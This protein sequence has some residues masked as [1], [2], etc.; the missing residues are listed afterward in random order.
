M[1]VEAFNEKLNPKIW[2]HDNNLHKD[3]RDKVLEIVTYFNDYVTIP[4]NI[5]DIQIVG[6]NASYN[7]NENSDLDIHII[8]DFSIYN[9]ADIEILKA[10]YNAEKTQFNNS[11]DI[12]IKGIEAEV[13]V[14]DVNQTTI[15]NGIYSLKDGWIKFPN[16]LDDIVVQNI[17]S[18]LNKWIQLI[19]DVKDGNSQDGAQELLD[20]IYMIRKNSLAVDGEYGIGNLLFKALRAKGYIQDLRNLRDK[21][22]SKKLTLE[23]LRFNKSTKLFEANRTQLI[24]KSK[25][26][27]KGRQRYNR[28]VK[29][30]MA[31]VVRDFNSIDMNKLFKDDILAVDVTVHGETD[32]YKVRMSFG[33]FLEILRDQIEK[34][35][36]LDL[37]AITR[38]LVIG[39]NKDDVY[40]HCT[41]PDFCLHEDTK[42]KLLNNEV[43]SIKDIYE[44]F[45][46]NE[47]LWV[48]SVDENG[49]FKPGKVTDVWISGKVKNLI[50]V[51]LDNDKEIV[52]T[53]NHRYMLRDGSFLE[54]SSLKEG[55]SLMPLYFSYH[56][57]YECVKLNSQTTATTFQS[58]YKIVADEILSD[59][60][61]EAKDRSKEDVICIHHA[62]F[63]K[64]NNF[65]SNLKPMGKNEHW[66][67]HYTH[68]H[69]SGEF[70]KWVAGCK[71]YWAKKESRDKQAI[72]MS[73]TMKQY[74]SNLSTEQISQIRKN[75]GAYTDEWKNN[76]SKSNKE[77]WK[78]Y[79][80]EEYE[81][82]CNLIKECNNRPDVKLKQSQKRKQYYIDHPEH[83][84][85]CLQ[86]IKLASQKIKGS[87]L[88]EEHKEKIRQAHL[89]FSKEAEE[90]RILKLRKTLNS[91]S[92]EE[93]DL[94][95]LHNRD[96][97]LL[98]II[99]YML[100]NGISLSFENYKQCMKLPQYY[101][102]SYPYIGKYFTTIEDAI[103]YFGLNNN[104]NHKIKRIEIVQ[105][106]TEVPVYDL[107][108]DKY[109]NFYVDAG[110]ILHNCYR[111]DYYATRNIYNSGE[112]Q[113]IPSKITNPRDS[114]GSGCK[115]ILLLLSNT[116]WL[117]K[118]ASVINNYIKY[119]Q[120]NMQRAYTDIIYPAIYGKEYEEPVQLSIFDKDDLDTDE[121]TIDKS[122]QY[123]R[124][125]TQ[126]KKGNTQGVRFAPNNSNDDQ[127]T[128]DD[129]FFN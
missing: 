116:A 27:E 62:D 7:W 47:E 72:Q 105:L 57:G 84:E 29:S 34:A 112:P 24:N 66:K 103:E 59:K 30:K 97:K 86:N 80:K 18:D 52:T 122:N 31:N 109:N 89:N 120:K 51:I 124:T 76:I 28:R 92:Q 26:S 111:F 58:V 128:I 36:K 53:P 74:Y 100:Q 22:I 87:H 91:K 33:G 63:N 127:I 118:V 44:R 126:F 121:T 38:A 56:N 81:N 8:C 13:Y 37:R 5:L 46:N 19:T 67:Y 43:L 61:E 12:V 83:K 110:V 96:S 90:S 70:D 4:L 48:Y 88:T 16:K 20:K 2:D 21:D 82:R 23:G 79:S 114:L 49:D 117:I 123:G 55:Q 9:Y 99:N 64:L 42:I 60:I 106:D 65:P 78:N 54:A 17:S 107:T 73:N 101:K 129:E 93:K 39:F 75:S 41:C 14:E 6:S 69:E 102:K 95:K 104:Y 108:V 77:A 50:K 3:V 94:I 125:S 71:A 25:N 113:N 119:A 98:T 15:S 115:H 68:L 85:I 45:K 35:G 11:Y 40:I 32:D 1:I 10:L